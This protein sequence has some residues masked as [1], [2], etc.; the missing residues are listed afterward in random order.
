MKLISFNVN[1]I[2]AAVKKGL[3]D[4]MAEMDAD[5]IC[6][7]ETKANDQQ[8]AEALFGTGYHVVS[9][10]AQKAGYSGTAIACKTEPLATFKN[11]GIAQ[12]DQEGRL[13]GAEFEKF[14]LVNCY[15]PNSK[16]DL[17]RLDYRHQWDKDLRAYLLNLQ[18]TKP[19]VFCG[20]LNVCHRPIDI[21]RPEANYNKSAGYTQVEIDGLDALQNEGFIDTFR[22][23][24]PDK[25]KYSWWSF[26]AGARA[27]NIGWRLDYF[28]ISGALQPRLKDAFILNAVMGSDHCPVGVQLAV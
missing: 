15:V 5:V 10:S 22:Y 14:Y 27:R 21:A 18:Q 7:Q 6:F 4:A 26:R 17:S 20:D 19:V 24:Y 13:I 12:H 2:R 11:M 23:L 16:N 1:G 3:H 28:L 9:N 25:V 8:V